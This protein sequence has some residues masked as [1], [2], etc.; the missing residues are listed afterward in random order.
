SPRD[1]NSSVGRRRGEPREAARSAMW[2]IGPAARQSGRP[3]PANLPGRAEL[4]RLTLSI[5]AI[6][7]RQNDSIP[8]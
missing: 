1:G 7:P 5:G 4:R 3:P 6:P 8:R 2:C